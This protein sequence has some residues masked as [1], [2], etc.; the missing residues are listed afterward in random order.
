ML[1]KLLLS[2]LAATMLLTS[3]AG[4]TVSAD[5]VQNGATDTNSTS[6]V[7]PSNSDSSTGIVTV[8]RN[9][10]D[11][12]N[13][14]A[15]ISNPVPVR[16]GWMNVVK[17]YRFNRNKFTGNDSDFSDYRYERIPSSSHE[18]SYRNSKI[19]GGWNYNRYQHVNYY[20][21]GY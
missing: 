13:Q 17:S 18:T 19:G 21:G 14:A 10:P 1:K 6:Q 4:L 7:T 2:S 15:G 16:S 12:D 9:N 8:D 11:L 3:S 20:S 5:S